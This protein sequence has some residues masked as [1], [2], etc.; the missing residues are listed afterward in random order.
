MASQIAGNCDPNLVEIAR[1]VCSK[2]GIDFDSLSVHQT[3]G[4]MCY[5]CS[6]CSRIYPLNHLTISRRKKVC[7][8]CNNAVKL[9]AT[10]NKFGKL[11]RTI[12]FKQLIEFKKSR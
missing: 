3:R 10:S 2:E 6:Y 8:Q 11:R 9:Y 5:W 4:L 7:T 12:F 1:E